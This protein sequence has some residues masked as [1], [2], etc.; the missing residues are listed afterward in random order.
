MPWWVVLLLL[1]ALFVAWAVRVATTRG[2]CVAGG[3]TTV[4]TA[5]GVRTSTAD[6]GT[7]DSQQ[8]SAG[9]AYTETKKA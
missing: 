2:T 7:A 1:S 4:V 9:R 6:G 3:L 5:A 8:R